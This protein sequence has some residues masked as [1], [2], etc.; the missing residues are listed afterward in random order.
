MGGSFYDYLILY[1]RTESYDHEKKRKL[2][3]ND[4]PGRI[5]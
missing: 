3:G 1:V 4:D 2:L 5:L